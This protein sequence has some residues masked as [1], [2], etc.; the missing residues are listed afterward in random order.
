[1]FTL[2]YGTH[3]GQNIGTA[4][5]DISPEVQRAK[6]LSPTVNPQELEEAII[7]EAIKND[8]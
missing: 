5:A 7:C 4:L 6:C 2:Q 1:M 8:S 3:R